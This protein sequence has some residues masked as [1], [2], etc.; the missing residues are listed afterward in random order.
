MGFTYHF[1]LHFRVNSLFHHNGLMANPEKF[2]LM[3][4]GNTGQAFSSVVNETYIV[5]GADI[6]LLVVNINS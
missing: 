2:H 4:L 1:N 6:D 3:T 5:K